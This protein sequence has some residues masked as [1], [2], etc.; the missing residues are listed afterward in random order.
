[1]A[2]TTHTPRFAPS[3]D[4]PPL[5]A[6]GR[7]GPPPTGWRVWVRNPPRSQRETQ[8]RATLDQIHGQA[9]HPLTLPRPADRL[10]AASAVIAAD[11]AH[12]RPVWRRG[13]VHRLL[14][15]G[16]IAGHSLD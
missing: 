11:A 12:E 3:R 2:S 13:P 4:Q 14:A 9:A 8:P 7:G 15:I 6:H 16:V 5:C 10:C 1:M